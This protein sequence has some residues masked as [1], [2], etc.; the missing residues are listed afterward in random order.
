MFIANF[1]NFIW[2]KYNGKNVKLIGRTGAFN[3]YRNASSM[4]N[5]LQDFGWCDG[6]W[7]AWRLWTFVELMVDIE[8][9]HIATIK[10]INNIMLLNKGE[11]KFCGNGK[12]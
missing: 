5:P 1:L 11:I 2:Y 3:P 8:T 12:I 9:F 6:K 7:F 4:L 10:E